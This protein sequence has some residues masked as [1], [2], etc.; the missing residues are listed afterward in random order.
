M[1]LTE[2]QRRGKKKYRATKKGKE[3]TRRYNATPKAR[4][5]IAAWKRRPEVKDKQKAR[6][7]WLK[8][9][10]GL[11]LEEF[12]RAFADQ[13]G[14]C[15]ICGTHQTELSVSLHVDHDHVTGRIRGLLCGP[16]NRM[17]GMAKDD[18]GRLEAA[19]A[20]LRERS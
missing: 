5:A 6:K 11:T 9:R 10:F 16:C 15:A 17:L 12:N 4:A 8:Q 3:T 13:E 19:I 18:I 14:R 20:Y 1:P 2:A 7:A